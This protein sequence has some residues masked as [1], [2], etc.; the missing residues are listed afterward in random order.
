[1]IVS[2]EDL[3]NVHIEKITFLG[4]VY[5]EPN[6]DA[7]PRRDRTFKNTDYG[8]GLQVA[9]ALTGSNAKRKD[10]QGKVYNI[11]INNCN[12]LDI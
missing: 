7:Y 1:L 8:T 11:E 2:A 9:I 3:E 10:V 12:F 4:N 5:R 6:E